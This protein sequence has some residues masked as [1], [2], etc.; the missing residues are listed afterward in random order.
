MKKNLLNFIKKQSKI[1][2]KKQLKILIKKNKLKNNNFY[3]IILIY[4][5]NKYI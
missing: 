2:I 1:L 4:I 5:F 3:F